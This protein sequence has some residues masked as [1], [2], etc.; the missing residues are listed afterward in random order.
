MAVNCKIGRG[1]IFTLFMVVSCNGQENV[2]LT[3]N[4]FS[5]HRIDSIV[6]PK[7]EE[8][9]LEKIVFS[10]G[11]GVDQKDVLKINI[12]KSHI[13]YQGSFWIIFYSQNKKWETSWGFHDMGYIIND[14]INVYDKGVSK[15]KRKLEKP[16]ELLVYFYNRDKAKKIDSII[17]SSILREKISRTIVDG[18]E[19]QNSENREIIFDFEKIKKNS[20]FD[21]W[22]SGK[23]YKAI[24]EHDFD[25]WNNN[26]VFLY[27][28]NG[29][30]ISTNQ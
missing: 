13:W 29:Q 3:V 10:D 27:F 12:D 24:I 16:K 6:I 30:I 14:T 26:Q 2:N 22:I 4:N 25:D 19:S 9:A 15:G 8:K 1:F 5:S 11:I 20:E 21:V 18:R 7:N 23:K 28:K 17:S